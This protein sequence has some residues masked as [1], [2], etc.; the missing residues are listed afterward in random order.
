MGVTP[1]FCFM[2]WV[3][4]ECHVKLQLGFICPQQFLPILL[5]KQNV[6]YSNKKHQVHTRVTRVIDSFSIY[7]KVLG[8]AFV[9]YQSYPWTL[10]VYL[11]P[12]KKNSQ[13]KVQ[14]SSMGILHRVQWELKACFYVTNHVQTIVWWW[15]GSMCVLHVHFLSF[16]KA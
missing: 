4:C 16:V 13:Y 9:S 10:V 15:F 2:W 8:G 7:S 1:S 11:A 12:T 6:N 5:F 3:V 14:V